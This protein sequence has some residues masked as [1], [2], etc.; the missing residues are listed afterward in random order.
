VAGGALRAYIY[1]FMGQNAMTTKVNQQYTDAEAE[2]RATD[3]LR[4][5]LTTPYKPQRAMIG[6]VGRNAPGKRTKK[7]RPKSP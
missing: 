3:A 1:S 2:R 7:R 4:R 5:A 6:K